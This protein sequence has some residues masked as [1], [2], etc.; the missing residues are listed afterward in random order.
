[1]ITTGCRVRLDNV[2]VYSEATPI[3]CKEKKIRIFLCPQ[4][5]CLLCSARRVSPRKMVPDRSVQREWLPSPKCSQFNPE[6][7]V[8]FRGRGCRPRS[9]R[10]TEL[11]PLASY[12]DGP[13]VSGVHATSLHSPDLPRS[14]RVARGVPLTSRP[15][16]SHPRSGSS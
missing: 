2:I 6:T 15:R 4:V 8:S 14:T 9:V 3:Q 10:P 5:M 16:F 11:G 13:A 1:M 12:H 7:Q